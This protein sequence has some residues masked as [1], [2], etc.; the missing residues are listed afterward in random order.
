[1]L[2]LFHQFSVLTLN[3]KFHCKI[4]LKKNGARGGSRSFPVSPT[5]THTHPKRAPGQLRGAGPM[6]AGI[7]DKAYRTPTVPRESEYKGLIVYVC[8]CVH[9]RSN[10][11]L[12]ILPAVLFGCLQS[13]C[14][15]VSIQLCLSDTVSQCLS[16]N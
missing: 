6:L 15:P 12:V 3:F 11:G 7:V 5:H 1:M 4:C 9:V 14:L 10:Q 2:H 8:V 13:F 16:Y